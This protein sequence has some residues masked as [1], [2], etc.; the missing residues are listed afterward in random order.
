MATNISNM[1]KDSPLVAMKGVANSGNTVRFGVEGTVPD[2]VFNPTQ[3]M[4]NQMKSSLQ[5]MNYASSKQMAEQGRTD[6]RGNV[7]GYAD[8][9]G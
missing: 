9:L 4:D 3:R 6:M 2:V 8:T 7:L 1:L 5:V